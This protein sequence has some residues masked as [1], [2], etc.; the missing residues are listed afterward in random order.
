MRSCLCGFDDCLLCEAKLYSGLSLEQ[1][2]R[3]RGLLSKRDIGAGVA[4]FREGS[5]SEHLFVLREGQLKLAVVTPDGREQIIGLA[6]RGQM[7]G[8]SNMNER[9]YPYTATTLTQSKIC[10]IRY[11][12]MLQVLEENPHVSLRTI[13]L[14]NDELARTQRLLRVIGRKTSAQK[15][16]AFILS[17]APVRGEPRYELPLLLS[18]EEIAAMLGLT[19]ET[20]SRV[21]ADLKRKGL[22]KARRRRVCILDEPQLKQLADGTELSVIPLNV[23][24]NRRQAI[25]SKLGVFAMGIRY[26][27]WYGWALS[28]KCCLFTS[29]LGDLC[30]LCCKFM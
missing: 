5:P 4:L 10:S 25:S 27:A 16:A 29:F 18:R 8:L 24:R 20:V 7:L 2:C 12:D 19:E 9:T 17:L 15:V 14:L 26:D 3:I 13:S 1:V 21:M 6:V 23:R 11:K 28:A 22:I 30:T